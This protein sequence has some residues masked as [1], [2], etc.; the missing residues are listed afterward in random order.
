MAWYYWSLVG[1]AIGTGSLALYV[2]ISPAYRRG[3]RFSLPVLPF[4]AIL[5]LHLFFCYVPVRWVC[6]GVDA[7]HIAYAAIA[8]GCGRAKRNPPPE[9]QSPH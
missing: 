1:L 7:L 6:L 3:E 2:A 9:Q 5:G 8:W 4:A